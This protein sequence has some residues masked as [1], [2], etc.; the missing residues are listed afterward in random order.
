MSIN[1]KKY[2][3]LSKISSSIFEVTP[4]QPLAKEVLEEMQKDIDCFM[5]EA[6]VN[7]EIYKAYQ[8]GKTIKEISF[9]F[10][11]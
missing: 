2:K 3:I 10:K 7:W 1:S 4:Y 6:K 8:L 5:Q 9:L 11:D